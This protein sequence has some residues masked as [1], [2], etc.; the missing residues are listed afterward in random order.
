[1]AYAKGNPKHGG[2]KKGSLNKI[3]LKTKELHSLITDFNTKNF[4]KFWKA[5]EE[6]TPFEKCKIYL[7]SLEY[8]LAKLQK[9]VIESNQ[10]SEKDDI[11]V[12]NFAGNQ[13]DPIVLVKNPTKKY[14]YEDIVKN[15]KKKNS[16][17]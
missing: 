1:M 5:W 15:E 17:T 11:T 14:K 12:V 6:C 2:R 9:T 16:G 3:T 13:I 7:S 4:Y 10:E 8:D